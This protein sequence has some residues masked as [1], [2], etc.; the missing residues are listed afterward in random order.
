ME[1]SRS[2]FFLAGIF[3]PAVI[4]FGIIAGAFF[5]SRYLVRKKY[6]LRTV[7]CLWVIVLILLLHGLFTCSQGLSYPISAALQTNAM[8][9]ITIG[10]VERVQLASYPPIYFDPISKRL[11]PAKFLTINGQQFYFPYCDVEIG[12]TV[13]LRWATNERV[14]YAYNIL[15]NGNG[16]NHSTYP[17]ELPGSSQQYY[18]Y[19]DLGQILVVVFA[20]L[21]I[22]GVVVQ[23]PVGKM[24]SVRFM[25]KDQEVVNSIIP[26]RFGLIYM[27][28]QFF[29]ILGI[30]GGLA[31]KGFTGAGFILLVSAIPITGLIVKKQTTTVRIEEGLLVVKSFGA[32]HRIQKESLVTASFVASSL[33]HN[34][35]LMI[36]L[37]NGMVFRFEQENY[38][39]LENMYKKIQE[40]LN[41][42]P[43]NK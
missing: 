17:I 4:Y 30:L 11:S 20:S 33:P 32:T 39:G 26:N 36:T 9:H 1:F 5:L 34:R 18:A 41:Q 31:L 13:E 14:V 10:C 27:C 40:A 2:V 25:K 12:Q 22:V 37:R 29:L 16:S 8:Q 21:F 24:L 43:S 15:Q 23:Y 28:I 6:R 19:A 7:I 35:C 38:Y 42:K 3:F